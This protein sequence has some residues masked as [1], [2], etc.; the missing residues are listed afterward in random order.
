MR[1]C[2]SIPIC[3]VHST[4]VL[5]RGV[6]YYRI[7]LRR[8]VGVVVVFAAYP[9]RYS[10]IQF[11]ACSSFVGRRS[12]F[13]LR[14]SSFVVRRSSFIVR[15]WSFV[16]RPSSF[17]LPSPSSFVVPSPSSFALR[18]SSFDIRGTTFVGRRSWDDV[19]GTTFVDV[20]TCGRVDVCPFFFVDVAAQRPRLAASLTTL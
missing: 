4:D 6:G 11:A 3:T 18:P 9:G 12:S 19:R 16:L 15:P 14:P 8:G 5:V 10:A 20:W 2:N 13:V 17:V 7:E 1:I